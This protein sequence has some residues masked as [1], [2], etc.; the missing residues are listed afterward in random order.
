VDDKITRIELR[1]LHVPF[2]A[3]TRQ[4]LQASAGGLGMAIKA[5]EPWPGGDFVICRLATGDGIEGVSEAFVWLPE[6]GVSPSQ[7]IDIIQKALHKYVI[8]AN[9]FDVKRICQR[10]DNNVARNEVAK[11]LLDMACYDLMGR[12]EGRP[13]C[14][15]M[16][17]KTIGEIP[18]A[19]LVW[20]TG[21]DTMVA[22]AKLFVGM[23]YRT[24]RIK[25]GKGEREDQAIMAAI[26]DEIGLEIRLRVDYNQ[27][28]TP[29]EAVDAI[30]AI[31]SFNID[32]AE[33]PVGAEDYMGM[34]VVQQRVNVP[35]M[36]HEGC[37]SVRDF[38]TL[39][40][41]GAVRVLGLNSE[42]PGGVTRALEAMDLAKQRNM[43]TV[44]HNQPLGIASAMQLHLAA[45]RFNDLGHAPE[46]FGHFMLED[47]L[48][49]KPIVYKNGTA[50]VP[51]GPGW[52]VDLDTKALEKYATGPA[53]EIT[54]P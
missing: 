40:E 16:G 14:E 12:I 24:L 25:L 49:K 29:Q 41:L 27:A 20:L 23:G 15:F 30:K 6:T 46:L 42:R 34:V 9:P 47:D 22:M 38:V 37:F 39:A 11:G 36:A 28:Y 35:L 4:A 32:V 48:I 1:P 45:A 8:G 19:A 7:I 33:Q 53:V 51:A 13:A 2:N 26:R 5:E 52:G 3:G 50:K 18:H 43:G 21:V 44:L 54:T 17:G 10:M 31:E